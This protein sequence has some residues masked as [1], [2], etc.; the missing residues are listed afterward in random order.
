[1]NCR[2]RK[3]RS[4]GRT[5]GSVEITL[6]P[7]LHSLEGVSCRLMIRDGVRPEIVLQPDLSMAHAVFEDLWGKLRL[8]LRES[9]EI[10]EFS[11]ADYK[12]SLFP[13]NLW[14]FRPPLSYVD[15]LAVS[16]ERPGPSS[17][18]SEALSRLLAGLAVGAAYRL[19]LAGSL[20][21]AFGDALAY[22]I[23]DV[24][25]GLGTD[26]ER[27]MAH[28]AFWESCPARPLGSSSDD[29]VWHW[30]RPGLQRVYEEFVAWQRNPEEYQ[31]AR[32]KWYRGLRIEVGMSIA[33][34]EG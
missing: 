9:G 19:E 25:P 18:A 34:S 12:L 11:L 26:F 13:C 28:L 24:S 4:S 14:Q 33:A 21:L 30:A 7:E 31:C 32:D 16:S 3:I 29:R 6:P 22:L 2:S 5:S 1:M 20:A 15:A 23:T 27:G 8:G 10:G 17:D